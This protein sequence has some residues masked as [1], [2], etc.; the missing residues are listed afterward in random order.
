MAKIQVT[1]NYNRS[2]PSG[3]VQVVVTPRVAK[4]NKGDE[5]QFT[6]NGMPGRMR[7]TFKEPHLFSRGVLDGDGSIT[8]AVKLSARTTYRCE[9]FDNVG[10]P[11]GSAD[12]D[13]G[14]AFEAGGN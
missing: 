3:K 13:E 9:L 7:I 8:V 1:V 14:G 4:V 6:R 2:V 5:V 10:N 11:L 12:G